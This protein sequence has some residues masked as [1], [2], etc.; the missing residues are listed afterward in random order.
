[1]SGN[2][3]NAHSQLETELRP[4]RSVSADIVRQSLRP[5]AG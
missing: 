4:A 5:P 1:M 3:F 2:R